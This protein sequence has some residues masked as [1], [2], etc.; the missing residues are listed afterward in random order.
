MN[1]SWI[2]KMVVTPGTDRRALRIDGVVVQQLVDCSLNATFADF[3]LC[4]S[5][6]FTKLDI[7]AV[8][9]EGHVTH[10]STFIVVTSFKWNTRLFVKDVTKC[11]SSR[12]HSNKT[13]GLLSANNKKIWNKV[14]LRQHLKKLSFFFLQ[15]VLP[16]INLSDTPSW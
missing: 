4:S 3:A 10:T 14:F 11:F 13:H 8:Y 5:S 6:K 16:V 7:R 9:K 1:C 15:L 2:T 12:T